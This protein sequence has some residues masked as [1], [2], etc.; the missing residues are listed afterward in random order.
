MTSFENKPLTNEHPSDDVSPESVM[1]LMKGY[2][3]NVRRGDGD[4]R[5][6]LLADIVVVDPETIRLIKSGE[7]RELSLGYNTSIVEVDGKNFMT[8]IRGNHLALVSSG[9]AGI[10]TIRDSAKKIVGGK[11]AKSKITLFDDDIIEIEEVEDTGV[12][13]EVELEK[14]TP[15]MDSS[16]MVAAQQET[17]ALLRRLIDLMESKS[18]MI[19]EDNMVEIEE[20]TDEEVV[21]EETPEP[22]VDNDPVIEVDKDGDGHVKEDKIQDT[23]ANFANVASE[24]KEPGDELQRTSWQNFYDNNKK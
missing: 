14:E 11:M 12:V 3:I 17:N 19:V 15:V 20:I 6:C 13:G 4:L 18:E 1:S 23:Y 22:M 8:N 21:I 24:K 2:M 16:D 7:K 9:R 10:A 5:H